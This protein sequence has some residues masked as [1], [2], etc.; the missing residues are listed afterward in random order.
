MAMNEYVPVSGPAPG[1]TQDRPGES[2]AIGA[3]LPSMLLHRARHS[4]G[5][6]IL[7][8]KDRGIWNE[9]TWADL[10][11]HARRLGMGLAALG[12]SG[13]DRAAVMADTGPDWAY[14]D[15]GILGVGGVS[16]G[17]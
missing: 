3:S 1:G 6:V 2:A 4:A 16:V 13:G 15:L 11:A 17:I 7:R 12:F 5:R 14:A 10:A 8:K 9:V